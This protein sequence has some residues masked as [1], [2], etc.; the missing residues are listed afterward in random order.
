MSSF[1]LLK[2]IEREKKE[3]DFKLLDERERKMTSTPLH[4]QL[5]NEMIV[6]RT[7]THRPFRR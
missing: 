5:K 2:T 4:V 3:M 1:F 6:F 7:L